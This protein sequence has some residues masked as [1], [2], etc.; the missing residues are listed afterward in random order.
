MAKL[1]VQVTTNDGDVRKGTVEGTRHNTEMVVKK[2]VLDLGL[3]MRDVREAI[4]L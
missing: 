2:A 4:I 3:S 1:T